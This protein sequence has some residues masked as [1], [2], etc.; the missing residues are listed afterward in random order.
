MEFIPEEIEN[1]AY[2]HTGKEGELLVRLEKETHDNLEIPQMLTGR[3][4]GRLLRLLALLV[5]AK[6]IVEVGTFSGYSALSMAEALPE[7]GELFTCDEDPICLAVARKFMAE[8]SHGQKIK[9]L[10]GDAIKT[11]KKLEGPFDMAFID[12]DKKNYENYYEIILP[13]VRSG[14]LILVDN[15]LWGGSVLNPVEE[16]AH[17]INEFN[18]KITLD[19]RIDQVLITVRDGIYCLRKK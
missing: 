18:K 12:A 7:D 17:A 19:K 16:S 2:N 10:E 8:S 4:E 15:V 3:V 9:I 11:L 13:M 6:R 1:Y 14:G 5:K